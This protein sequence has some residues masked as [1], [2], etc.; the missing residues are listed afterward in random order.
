MANAH[1]FTDEEAEAAGTNGTKPKRKKFTPPPPIDAGLDSVDEIVKRITESSDPDA[2]WEQV[3]VVARL[4]LPAYG[5]VKMRLKK[6][7]GKALNLNDL[8]RAVGE[9]RRKEQQRKQ[10]EQQH[11]QEEQNHGAK[12]ITGT[13]GFALWNQDWYFGQY[14]SRLRYVKANDTWY[15]FNSKWW[16]PDVQQ[17]AY[18]LGYEAVRAIYQRLALEKVREQRDEWKRIANKLDDAKAIAAMVKA[19]STAPPIASRLDMFDTNDMHVV[20][21]NGVIDLRTG[22]LLS[23]SADQF[24]TKHLGGRASL[25]YDQ[26]ATCPNWLAFLDKIFE[27]KAELIAFVQRAFGY[28][29]TGDTSEE[30]WFLLTGGGNNG[31]STL[32]QALRVLMGTYAGTIP[33]STL[34]A[35]HTEQIPADIAKLFNVRAAFAGENE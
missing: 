7:F 23:H 31:K 35:K 6:H 20:A 19:A 15:G 16:D 30:V 13:A 10:E 5:A 22:K 21:A 17:I 2:V 29:L 27:Q 4:N 32:V 1:P 24:Y 3:G 25:V 11:K 33:Q 14:G 28:S 18:Q 9:E 34:M 8:D 26:E 12:K